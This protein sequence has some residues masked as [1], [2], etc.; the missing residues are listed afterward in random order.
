MEG[1]LKKYL[2]V[3]RGYKLRYF[4]LYEDTLVYSEEKGK[5]IIG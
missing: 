5:K 3:F 2:N 4:I 1:Y